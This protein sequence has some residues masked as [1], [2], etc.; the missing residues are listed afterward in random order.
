MPNLFMTEREKK[1]IHPKKSMN[2]IYK[3]L[4]KKVKNQIEQGSC[5]MKMK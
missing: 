5:E 3:I 1:N 2:R 4:M